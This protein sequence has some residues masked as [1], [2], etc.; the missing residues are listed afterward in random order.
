MLKIFQN[1]KIIDN[2]KNNSIIISSQNNLF[3]LK[4]M[5]I[6]KNV[7]ITTF[8]SYIKKIV[9]KKVIDNT[10]SFIYMYKA[11]NNV[12]KELTKY[13]D[14]DDIS[15]INILL[16]TYN[17]YKENNVLDNDKIKNLRIIFDEYEKIVNENDYITNYQMYDLIKDNIEKT[18]Y[19]N[20]YFYDIKEL[21]KYEV[22]FIN[23]LKE[24][25]NIYV[26]ANTIN[27]ISLV[28][29]LNKIDKILYEETNNNDVNNL[30]KIGSNN[31]FEGFNLVSCNDLYEEIRYISNDIKNKINNG[32]KFKDIL[33]ISNDIN[34][35]NNYFELLFDLPYN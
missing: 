33:I 31:L 11:F 12:K 6:D 3:K 20:I 27:N 28:E 4:E 2:I 14:E 16:N 21:K 24:N 23:L 30:F 9:N 29:D 13:K 25:K 32:L 34:R 8:D 19:D 15:F 35:Y 17:F 10:K 26:Y 1:K 22:D 7:L 5:F 18:S